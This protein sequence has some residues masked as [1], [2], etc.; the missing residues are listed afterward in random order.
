MDMDRKEA[1]ELLLKG[2]QYVMTLLHRLFGGEPTREMLQ[3]AAGED[4]LAAIALF[5]SEETSGAS[6]LLEA[7]SPLKALTDDELEGIRQEYTRLF[8]GPEELVAP[9][10]ESVY[11]T[12]ARALFQESTLQVRQWYQRYGYQPA[13]YPNYPD[14]HI[15]LML[16]FLALLSG[17]AL[18]CLR[19]NR[20]EAYRDIL[21]GQQVFSQSHLLNWLP[22]YAADMGKSATCLLYPRLAAALRRILEEDQA[23]LDELLHAD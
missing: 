23:L 13:G 2:R 7:L 1:A 15:S 8:I 3:A 10:W 5:D 4:S 17:E 12:K 21:K 6:L 14:D 22:R 9:P 11:V 18:A 20:V 19:E 16:H